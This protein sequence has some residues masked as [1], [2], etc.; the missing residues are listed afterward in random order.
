[1]NYDVGQG[2]KGGIHRV[3]GYVK[4]GGIIGGKF[5]IIDHIKLI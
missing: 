1:M 5:K 4:I 3:I 2:E